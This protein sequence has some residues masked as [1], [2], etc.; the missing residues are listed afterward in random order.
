MKNNDNAIL[1]LPFT[2]TSLNQLTGFPYRE[3]RLP[4]EIFI[5]AS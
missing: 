3:K 1:D 2:I 4:E 5:N